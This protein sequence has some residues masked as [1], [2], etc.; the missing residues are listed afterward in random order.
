MLR[1]RL[2]QNDAA[3]NELKQVKALLKFKEGPSFPKDYVGLTASVIGRPSGAFAQSVVVSVGS[4]DGVE[5]QAPVVTAQG[6]VGR[7]PGPVPDPPAGRDRRRRRLRDP[8]KEGVCE[9]P[10]NA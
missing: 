9:A 10:Q 7:A 8:G 6:L 3:A 1:Q 2:I 4:C 5:K